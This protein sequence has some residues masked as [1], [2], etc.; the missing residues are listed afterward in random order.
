LNPYEIWLFTVIV[1]AISLAGNIAARMAGAARG[2]LVSGLAG[3]LVSSTAVTVAFAH[4]ARNH[5]HDPDHRHMT[6]LSGG[7]C[8][9]AAV[10]VARVMVIVLLVQ[11]AV[12]PVMGFA[13]LTAA[14]VFAA[15]GVF[16]L[17]RGA[18]RDEASFV[19]PPVF[20]VLH[21]LVFAM[22]FAVMSMAGAALVAAFGDAGVLAVSG[23]SG[24]FDV[25]VAVFGALRLVEQSV[26]ADVAGYGVLAA[27]AANAL[28]RLSLAVAVGPRAY[29]LP[30]ALATA[31]A[32]LAATAVFTAGWFL[33]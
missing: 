26:T 14:A 33:F 30:L 8:C 13:A 20:R 11:P 3:A 2:L 32:A 28:G 21:L 10:S 22:A 4:I 17:S 29:F 1:A 7:A 18:A 5:V 16:L 31:L 19:A 9:A 12:F 23:L 6:A 25:D 27:L 15:C 24:V